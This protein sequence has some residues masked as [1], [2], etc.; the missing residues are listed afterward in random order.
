MSS[1]C[2][3]CKVVHIQ[4]NWHFAAG[5]VARA[6]AAPF[7]SISPAHFV[8]VGSSCTQPSIHIFAIENFCD[9]MCAAASKHPTKPIIVCAEYNNV[10]SISD[11]C[12]LLGAYLILRQDLEIGTLN[13]SH[14]HT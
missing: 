7:C 9:M 3:T 1:S 14:N 12:L 6:L 2:S 4:G 5:N 8:E 10:N 11:A 13:Q